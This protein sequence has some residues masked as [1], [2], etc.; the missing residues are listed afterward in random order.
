MFYRR[1]TGSNYRLNPTT[2]PLTRAWRRK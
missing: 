1:G 2:V